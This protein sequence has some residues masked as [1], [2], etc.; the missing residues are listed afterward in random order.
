MARTRSEG[1]GDK[2]THILNVAATMFAEL[3]Y[4]GCRM[5]DI[6]ERCD[7]SKSMLY[8]YFSR[9]EDLL[10]EILREHVTN[11]NS[12]IEVY[13]G[14]A[15]RKDQLEYF[16]GFLDKYL[17]Q[18]TKAREKHAVTIRDTRWLTPSQL[19]I[20]EHLE[21][22]NIELIVE[23]LKVVLDGYS[24]KEYRVYALLLIGMINWIELWFNPSG[25]IPRAELYDRVS[26]LF[27]KGFLEK[28]KK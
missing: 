6:A 16:S 14:T 5:E 13:L 17:E 9:K 8:H 1:Y 11:L 15:E 7:V 26:L 4:V 20:Q 10:F 23:V 2:K 24:A 19:A 21:R 27:I 28:F 12:T 22:R 25:P 3:G 18:A